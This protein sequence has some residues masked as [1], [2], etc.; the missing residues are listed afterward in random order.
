VTEEWTRNNFEEIVFFTVGQS[1]KI[2]TI[3][4]LK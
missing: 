4:A 3:F 1:G 2:L